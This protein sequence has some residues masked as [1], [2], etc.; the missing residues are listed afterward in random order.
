MA[1]SET[2]QL[3]CL[4]CGRTAPPGGDWESATHPKLGSMTQCPECGSTNVQTKR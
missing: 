3:R 2:K 4:E 1:E